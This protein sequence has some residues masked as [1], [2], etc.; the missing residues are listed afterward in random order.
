MTIPFGRR[1]MNIT[2]SRSSARTRGWEQLAAAGM[3]DQELSR[4]NQRNTCTYEGA[5]WVRLRLIYT[6]GRRP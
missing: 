4:L 1:R 3:D 5:P 2:L 6:D